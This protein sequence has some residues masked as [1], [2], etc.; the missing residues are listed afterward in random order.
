MKVIKLIKRSKNN[1]ITK[2]KTALNFKKIILLK[3]Y[4]SSYFESVNF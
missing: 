1:L 2:D 3:R 4:E